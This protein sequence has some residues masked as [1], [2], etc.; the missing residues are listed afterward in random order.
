VGYHSCNLGSIE[1]IYTEQVGEKIVENRVIRASV[2]DEELDAREVKEFEHHDLA[3]ALKW[4]EEK[5]N[6][7]SM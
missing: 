3:L 7:L 2:Y 4:V 1:R 6:Q 5:M